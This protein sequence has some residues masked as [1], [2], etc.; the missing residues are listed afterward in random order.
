MQLGVD[1]SDD[2]CDYTSSKQ[3]E[4]T[5]I[6]M[7]IYI[8]EY[9]EIEDAVEYFIAHR[10]LLPSGN[11]SGNASTLSMT[12]KELKEGSKQLQ[13]LGEGSMSICTYD[14]FA[15]AVNKNSF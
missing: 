6:M 4:G 10:K 7:G 14:S 5:R 2:M 15:R 8:T 11:Y 13:E 12:G 3:T 1:I 9:E